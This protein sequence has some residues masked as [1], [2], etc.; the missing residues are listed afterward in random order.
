MVAHFL[1]CLT[2]N[3]RAHFT[4]KSG[5]IALPPGW[6]GCFGEFNAAGAG[7]SISL[8]VGDTWTQHNTTYSACLLLMR[9]FHSVTAYAL[10]CALSST[11]WAQSTND[12]EVAA[13]VAREM[14]TEA[15]LKLEDLVPA[16]N[17]T[18]TLVTAKHLVRLGDV[19]GISDAFTFEGRINAHA[20]FTTLP[21]KH[22]GRP[23]IEFRW[24]NGERTVAVRNGTQLL[25]RTPYYVA[26]SLSGT[27][28]GD[29]N[30]RVELHVNGRLVASRN[31]Q[32]SSS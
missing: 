2:K 25:A 22:G 32:V 29:G 18:I 20:T 12:A 4:P 30:C 28:L 10:S 6:V 8:E 19:Q 1:R 14:V 26:N 23:N 3:F 17:W 31:F 16:E 11:V 15:S 13:R 24:F 27:A 21:G 9:I 7:A 5:H